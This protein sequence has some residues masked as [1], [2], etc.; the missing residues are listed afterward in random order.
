MAAEHGDRLDVGLDTGTA[1]R[2]G[3]GDDEDARDAHDVSG[4]AD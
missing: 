2:I 1:A 3:A 4:S